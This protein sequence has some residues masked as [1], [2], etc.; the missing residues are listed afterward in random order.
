MINH[1]HAGQENFNKL[2]GALRIGDG[3]QASQ[4]VLPTECSWPMRIDEN[5][6]G[7]T[8]VATRAARDLINKQKSA[9]LRGQT[10]TFS[11]K[12]W[13]VQAPEWNEIPAL[14]SVKLGSSAMML[15]N[16]YNGGSLV[17]VNGMM[18]T[19]ISVNAGYGVS[20]STPQGI[21]YVGV[22]EED[23]SRWIPIPGVF[24]GRGQQRME[25]TQPTG[26]VSYLP[27]VEAFALTV[28]KAQGLTLDKVQVVT[29]FTF[30]NKPALLYVA[31][32]RVHHGRG[33]YL[34]GRDSL[35]HACSVD[36]R[37]SV[38]I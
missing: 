3:Y 20:L 6:D 34:A 10:Y 22:K 26:G 13:G 35:V 21:Q 24:D 16:V 9:T 7:V 23:D 15:K 37:V 33:L 5:F 12:A 32:S 36:P 38:W 2:L 8:L 31:A 19:V 14:T 25:K 11:K 29:D 1:R 27:L 18:G 17:Q 4:L 28:H 30:R